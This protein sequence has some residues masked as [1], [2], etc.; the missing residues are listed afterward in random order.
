MYWSDE[1]YRIFGLKPQEFEMTYDTFLDYVHPEDRDYVDKA[2]KKALNEGSFD[3]NYRIVSA[4]GEERVVHSQSKVVFSEKNTPPVRIRGIIQDITEHIKG[5]EKI[6]HLANVV[7]SSD[8]SIFSQ[9]LKGIVTSW[10]KGAEQV[11][12]YSAEEI[13]GGKNVSTLEP[14]NLKGGNK[15]AD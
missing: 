8:D 2:V 11:Y 7:E 12:G 10:N 4:N 6:Q 3:I 9:S 13:L 1:L 5:E 15:K 14:E